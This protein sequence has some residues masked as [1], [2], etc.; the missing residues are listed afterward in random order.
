MMMVG[1]ISGRI[2][3]LSS[4]QPAPPSRR[5]ASIS[6]SGMPCRAARKTRKQNG[7]HCQTSTMITET[8]AQL[9]FDS[10]GM[11]VQPSGPPSS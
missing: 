5:A 2:T 7:V 1:I 3:S 11:P 4:V 10:Q 9:G 6:S 8:R